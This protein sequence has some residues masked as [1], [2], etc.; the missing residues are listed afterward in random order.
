MT[1]ASPRLRARRRGFHYKAYGPLVRILIAVR[2]VAV[3]ALAAVLGS[4]AFAGGCAGP[5]RAALDGVGTLDPTAMRWLPADQRLAVGLAHG[6]EADDAI[7]CEKLGS[8]YFVG[9]GVPK[10]PFHALSLWTYACQEGVGIAC[11]QAA[12]QLVQGEVIPRDLERAVALYD[13]GCS[14]GRGSACTA[15]GDLFTGGRAMTPAPRRAA[16][17]FKR[18][19]DRGDAPGC[20]ALAL[21]LLEGRGVA[22]DAGQ[23][24]ALLERACTREHA[25]S[26]RQLAT[27]HGE[28]LFVKADVAVAVAYE[29]RA[30]EAGH[31]PSCTDLG[32]RARD[33]GRSQDAMTDLDAGCDAGDTRGCALLGDA[34]TMHEPPD[35][36]LAA[37]GYARACQGGLW[38]ACGRVAALEGAGGIDEVRLRQLYE[39]ACDA[40]E[41]TA[42]DYLAGMMLDGIGGP[43][44][45]PGAARL[46]DRACEKDVASSCVHLAWM[47]RGD[48]GLE[49]LGWLERACDLDA[50]ACVVLGEVHELDMVAGSEVKQAADAYQRGCA[51]DDAGACERLASLY[52]RG[53]GV[54]RDDAVAARLF[55]VACDGGRAEACA[56]LGL[57]HE[58]GLGVNPDAA[59][60]GHYHAR[61]CE[62]GFAPACKKAPTAKVGNPA[63]SSSVPPK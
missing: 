14:H 5:P 31:G 45:P 58:K 54:T 36:A 48:G 16:R 19:C 60:S 7:A 41:M 26:C 23:G 29:R 44:D 3:F 9:R 32:L 52:Y 57:M 21:A 56:E 34:W 59:W 33:E 37:E 18:G 35:L 50:L 51:A 22:H 30:C 8:L 25:T 2:P 20:H 43:S 53:R 17:A 4:F 12:A 47:G 42:C 10:H 46:Y 40:G 24:I 27:L 55:S 13:A 11:E 61:A 49:P 6:C 62:L 28:G 39:L 63:A 38:E 1:D 15:V